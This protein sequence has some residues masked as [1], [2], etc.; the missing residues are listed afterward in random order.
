MDELLSQISKE[1]Q[2]TKKLPVSAR[3]PWLDAARGICMILVVFGHAIG[4]LSGADC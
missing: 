2:V 3:I 1:V 4:G